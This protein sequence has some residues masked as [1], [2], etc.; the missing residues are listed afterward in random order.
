MKPLVLGA[1]EKA[2]LELMARRPKTDQRTAQ[3][4]RT[5]TPSS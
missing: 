1:E 5:P 3:R 2:K 4:A